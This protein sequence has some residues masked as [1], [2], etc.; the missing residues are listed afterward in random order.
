MNKIQ[1]FVGMKTSK[2]DID[3]VRKLL[4]DEG[5]EPEITA[6]VEGLEP[7][8]TTE[9]V[10]PSRGS[11]PPRFAF[12]LEPLSP[13]LIFTLGAFAGGF[14]GEMGK[15][16]W[17]KLKKSIINIT[18]YLKERSGQKPNISL[19]SSSEAEKRF[20]AVLPSG[21][22]EDLEAAL[23]LLPIYLERLKTL[24]VGNCCGSTQN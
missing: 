18:T 21:N 8:I 23:D 10:R 3:E 11:L 5:L 6:E 20:I 1:I 7:E 2:K 24:K 19:K 22:Q 17:E 13:V 4:V 16:F 12:T 15:E 14:L 9:I